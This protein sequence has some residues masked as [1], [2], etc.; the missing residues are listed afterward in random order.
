MNLILFGPPGAGKGTQGELLSEGCRLERLSTGDMLREA[1][2]NDTALGRKARGIM[3]AGEL[4]PDDLILGIVRDVIE[5]NHA[6]GFIFDGFPRTREQAEQL[7]DLLVELARPLDAVVVLDVDDEVLLRR[8]SGRLSCPSCGAIYNVYTDAAAREGVCSACGGTLR[9]RAD[10]GEE[11]V[12][13]RLEVYRS[14]TRPLIDYYEDSPVPV[15]YVN[16][17]RTVPEVQADIVA[18]LRA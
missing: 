17:D 11:T 8:L 10:D 1:V 5:T 3:A 6:P 16:G 4:V 9:Q 12:R 18:V 13:R 14:Q 7:D 2:R 15:H